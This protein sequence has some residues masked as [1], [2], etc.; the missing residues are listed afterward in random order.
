MKHKIDYYS[1]DPHIVSY[2][3]ILNLLTSTKVTYAPTSNPIG[4]QTLIYDDK[5]I[6]TLSI[7]AAQDN[8]F[9]DRLQ[10]LSAFGKEHSWEGLVNAAEKH[11]NSVISIELEFTGDPKEYIQKV[12]PACRWLRENQIGLMLINDTYP[13]WSFHDHDDIWDIA[14][15]DL[16]DENCEHDDSSWGCEASSCVNDFSFT[17][18]TD[19]AEKQ[20]ALVIE[21][22]YLS[23]ELSIPGYDKVREIASFFKDTL[24][25]GKYQDIYIGMGI[26]KAMPEVRCLIGD[27]NG[28]DVNIVKCGECDDHYIIRCF[29]KVASRKGSFILEIKGSIV[30]DFASAFIELA[31]DLDE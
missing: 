30:D 3:E 1:A 16:D 11:T 10:S 23:I 17:L 14:N 8:D 5:T 28:I 27:F 21:Y 24:R 2:E 29:S 22:K 31:K 20:F 12:D 25:T 6:G 15:P 13:I 18:D 7:I 19:I 4:V 9:Q 26:Y